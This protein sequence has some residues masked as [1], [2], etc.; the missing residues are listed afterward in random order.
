[1]HEWWEKFFEAQLRKDGASK[2]LTLPDA[3][4]WVA[5]WLEKK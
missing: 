1:V 4:E 3:A 2:Q 5:K